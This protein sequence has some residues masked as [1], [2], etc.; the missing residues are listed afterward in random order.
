MKPDL[1]LS[2][3]ITIG[4]PLSCKSLSL[5]KV[6]AGFRVLQIHPLNLGLEFLV[7]KSRREQLLTLK[8]PGK[9]P[10]NDIITMSNLPTELLQ[11]LS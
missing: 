7:Y 8:Q 6:K 4:V 10:D 1:K 3:C 2:Y 5:L 9:P 11:L